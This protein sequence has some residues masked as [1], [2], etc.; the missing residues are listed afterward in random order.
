MATPIGNLGDITIRA[1]E[2]LAAA[3]G[4]LAEDTRV[5]RKLLTHYGID[6]AL[7]RFDA[8]SPDSTHAAIAARIFG[9]AAIALTS[10]A[11]TPLISDPG[12]PLVAA[13]RAAGAKVF[14]VPG[15]SAVIAALAGG[16]LPAESFFFDGFLPQKSGARRR[17]LRE[18]AA[19][20]GTLVF[21]EAP[22]RAVG[23]L[24]DAAAVF[25]ERRAVIGRELTKT[26]ETFYSGTALELHDLFAA[27][28]EVKGEI[29][30][31]I[32]PPEAEAAQAL[33]LDAALADALET[34]SV[35]DAA[36]VVAAKAGLPRR[37]VYARAVELAAKRKPA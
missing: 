21:Y 11:G 33:D 4:V 24:E 18:L 28:P 34:L 30:L 10:D 35:K 13:V 27:M 16:G 29:V 32:A 19:I 36:S 3:D 23:A 8:H 31:M 6:T 37:E 25:P 22:H 17:R 7:Q 12:E 14:P 9:G 5:G 1:L 2:T 15:A 26:F 20:P